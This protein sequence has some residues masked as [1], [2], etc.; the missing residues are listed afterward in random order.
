[1]IIGL[2][3]LP[4]LAPRAVEVSRSRSLAAPTLLIAWDKVTAF[5]EACET[6]IPR[7]GYKLGA[8]IPIDSAKPGTDFKAVGCSGFVR[9][10]IRRS[11]DGSVVQHDWIKAKKFT[12]GSV[13]DGKLK[14]DKIRIA[15]LT[16]EDSSAKIG[17]VVFVRNAL[18]AESHGG[19]GPNSHAFTGTGWQALAKVYVL[20]D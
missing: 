19:V 1:M 16:P 13:A 6:S 14:D 3:T 18:T 2:A 7:V 15:F 8:K 9:A 11:T 5:L 12:A 20:K 10:A 4:I 17:H